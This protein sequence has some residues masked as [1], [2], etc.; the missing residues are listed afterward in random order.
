MDAVVLV[1]GFGT[2]LQSVV[3]DVPKPLAPVN[4]RPFLDLLLEQLDRF[5]S[6]DRVVLATG[7]KGEMIRTRYQ[8]SRRFEFEI[9]VSHED[10]PLGTGGGLQQALAQVRSDQVLVLNGDSYVDFDLAALQVTHAA[11]RSAVTLVAVEVPD[12]ARFGCVRL[13]AD[14]DQVLGFEEKHGRHEPGWVNAGC[15]LI[16]R[17]SLRPWRGERLSL[18]TDILPALL[19]RTF[20]HRVRGKFIDIGIPDTYAAAGSYLD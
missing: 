6:V 19:S 13:R 12:A 16:E 17:D 14:D 11:R 20:A 7:Y 9:R 15:Y 5:D 4:G 8:E 2:R 10:T 1:G 18:E 3:R